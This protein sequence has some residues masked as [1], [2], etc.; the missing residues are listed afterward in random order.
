MAAAKKEEKKPVAWDQQK[1]RVKL[2]KDNER[3]KDD[4]TVVANGTAFRI[5]RGKEVEIPMYVWLILEASME[6]D[7]KTANLIQE[8]EDSYK[9][10]E[11]IY[12][13]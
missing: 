5:Q 8:E 4:V 11:A 9:D 10:K 13:I 7:A 1:V 2:F 6:Q 12:A 3:Y